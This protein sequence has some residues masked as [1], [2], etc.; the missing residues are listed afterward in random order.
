[1]VGGDDQAVTRLVHRAH[2][3]A[4]HVEAID[5]RVDELVDR[6]PEIRCPGVESAH[7]ALR[8]DEDEAPA[9]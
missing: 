3:D 9:G 5:H 2:G 1:V 8:L 7:P 6:A 4:V